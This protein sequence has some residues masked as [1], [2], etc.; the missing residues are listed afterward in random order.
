MIKGHMIEATEFMEL[1][2]HYG[3]MGVPKVV[4]NDSVSFE[5]AYPED[6]FLEYVLQAAKA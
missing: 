2:Q 3:V 5:G 1:A 6:A 4:I